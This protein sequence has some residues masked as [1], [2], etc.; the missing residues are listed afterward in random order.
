M[1]LILALS[2]L[3]A[4]AVAAPASQ[5]AQASVVKNDAD[6]APDSYNYSYETS[7]GISAGEQGQL[8]NAGSET[9]SLAVRGEFKYT[10][11]DGVVYQVSYVADDNGFQPLG[12]HL[13]VSH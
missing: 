4:V 9:E 11:P 6:V 13:P 12:A 5:D 3:A 10:G 2:A 1:K 8:N 7:N